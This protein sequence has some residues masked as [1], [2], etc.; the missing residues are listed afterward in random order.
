MSATSDYKISFTTFHNVIDN[1]LTET[2]TTRHTVCPSNEE[3]LWES[4][5]STDEDVNHAVDAANR[6]FRSWS[7]LSQDTRAE[8]LIKFA[9]AVEANKQD[10]IDL[11]GKEVGKP[12]QAAAYEMLFVTGLAREIPKLRLKEEKPVDDADRTAIVRYVP[13]GVGVG[14]VPWNFPLV[15]GFGKLLSALLAGNTFIWKPSPYSPYS[16]LKLAELGTKVFPP[17]VFQALSGEDTLGPL[18]TAHPGVAKISFTGSVETGKKVMAACASTLK[19]IT[20]ELGGNDAAIVCEDV[21]IDS[22]VAKVAFLAFV[23]VGQI[24]MNIKRIYVHESIYDKFLTALVVTTKQFKIGDHTDPEAVFGPVQNRMQHEKLQKFYSQ[25]SKEGWK[26]A[27]GGEPGPTQ[28]KGFFMPPTIIDNPPEDSSIVVDEPF[29]PIVPVLKWSNEED[30]IKR[31]NASKLGLGASVWSKDVSRAQKMAEQLEAGSI[32]VNTHFELA[33]N[34]PFGGH[35]ES[36]L[37]M[38]WGQVGLE[39][40]CNPQA[41]WVKH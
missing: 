32:W 2:A 12:P 27:L 37:G 36:G 33:P 18:L 17:G 35:K 29:G 3:P 9:D 11:L 30:V 22:V 4:P 26:T 40:W 38:E 21:D 28:E 19:R 14:I 10:F 20:L 34:V 13:L 8:Y 24:C 23:H 15:L 39:G 25:I 31:A 7:K 16:A 6:A 1:E 5:V 41:Y